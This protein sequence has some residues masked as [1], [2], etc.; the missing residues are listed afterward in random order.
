MFEPIIWNIL[1]ILIRIRIDAMLLDTQ[2][3]WRRWQE[4]ILRVQIREQSKIHNTWPN[5]GNA[6]RTSTKEDI[7]FPLGIF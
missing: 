4:E 6:P 7:P 2:D 3:S 5:N 1:I